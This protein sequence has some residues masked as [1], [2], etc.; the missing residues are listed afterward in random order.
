MRNW[1]NQND[2]PTKGYFCI[3]RNGSTLS[4]LLSPYENL[5]FRYDNKYTY[6]DVRNR[7][8]T[9][10]Q[11]LLKFGIEIL[12]YG[13]DGVSRELKMMREHLKLGL[14]QKRSMY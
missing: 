12:T 3:R 8:H 6:S 2:I 13:A 1:H 9:I 10:Q 4:G 11:E 5:H 7:L 14:V